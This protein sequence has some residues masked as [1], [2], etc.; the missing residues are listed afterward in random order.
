[1][2]ANVF[3][4]L[5]ATA[6]YEGSGLKPV[7]KGKLIRRNMPSPLADKTLFDL[8]AVFSR[9]NIGIARES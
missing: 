4:R 8:L 7:R 5:S 6:G 1:M 3:K 2:I 9:E